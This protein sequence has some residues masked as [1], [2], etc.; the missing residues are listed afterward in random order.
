MA[1]LISLQEVCFAYART[2]SPALD[3]INLTVAEGDFLLLTGQTGC[4]KSTLLKLLNGLI[5]HESGGCLSGEA[6]VDGIDVGLSSVSELSRKVGMMFQC[7]DD[8][9]F[10][11]TPYDEVSFALENLGLEAQ[12]ISLRT[13]KALRQVGLEDKAN[14]SIHA[15]SGGQKQRLAL[16]AAIATRPRILALDEPISQLDP[17]GAADLMEIVGQL[18]R[19]CGVTVIL[20]E[21]RLHEILHLCNRVVIMEKGRLKWSGSRNAALADRS[22]FTQNG[23]RL[24][25]ALSICHELGIFRE[26]FTPVDAATAINAHYQ[27]KVKTLPVRKKKSG[28]VSEPVLE[29]K[30]LCFSYRKATQPILSDVS[31]K[32]RRGEFVAL[33]GNNGAGKSTLLQQ[34]AGLLQPDRGTVLHCGRKVAVDGKR[35]GMVL[36]N[37]D[38][39]L[40]NASVLKEVAFGSDE[41]IAPEKLMQ[42]LELNDLKERFPLSLSRGQ[43]LRTAVA[44]VLACKPDVLLLDEPTTGQDISHIEEIIALLQEYTREG[45]SLLFCTH[46]GE[47]AAH[48][49]DRIIVMHEGTIAAQGSPD[50][51]FSQCD[52][53]EKSGLK[54]P[55]ALEISRFLYGGT[56]LTTKEVVEDVRQSFMG[57]YA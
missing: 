10:S 54:R 41:R 13:L 36:Q 53:L 30:D 18:N 7:P 24:P 17:Q 57:G 22:L 46:D 21:H 20:V 27:R 14:D 32:I 31:I 52:L 11:M 48:Y 8:Q 56:A 42:K 16:A 23:L 26:V 4:G 3:N 33:M 35:I 28:S 51:I 50:E 1:E 37:P 6:K 5:P 44:A 40:F 39:M 45:G 25:Q 19:E 38:L 43:R 2:A 47:I 15:L 34:A 12:D 29:L 49:A 55:A 9:I